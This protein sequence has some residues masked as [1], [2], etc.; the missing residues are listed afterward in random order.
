M[1]SETGV[2]HVEVTGCMTYLQKSSFCETK[3]MSR[4]TQEEEEGQN[5][6]S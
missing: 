2:D 5:F 6:E 4:H 3:A 1:M